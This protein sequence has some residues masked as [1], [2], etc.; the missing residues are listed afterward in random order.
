MSEDPHSEEPSPTDL[1]DQ[2]PPKTQGILRFIGVYLVPP[3]ALA[4]AA[5]VYFWAV[6]AVQRKSETEGEIAARIA[7]V[8]RLQIANGE[9]N[10]GAAPPSPTSTPDP[11]ADLGKKV[12]EGGCN[13]CH[14]EGL[15]GAPKIGDTRAWK[16]RLGKG[17]DALVA[18]AIQGV[19]GDSGVMPPR[20]GRGELSDEQIRAAVGFMV[21]TIRGGGTDAPIATESPGQAV[22]GSVCFVCHGTRPAAGGVAT[23]GIAGAP[24]IGDKKDWQTRARAGTAML[25]AHAIKGFQGKA[26]L[27][28]PKGGR[29][30]LT[31]DAIKAAVGYLLEQAK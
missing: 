29:D 30:D 4:F 1:E 28:P 21:A 14:T 2:A 22:Y 15:A 13:A 23:D 9:D 31:D 6:F 5:G 7:P 16:G 19:A 24:K 3:L 25:E 8:G 26:G 11:Q 10:G 18:N 12:Y 20:G 27:M 17:S